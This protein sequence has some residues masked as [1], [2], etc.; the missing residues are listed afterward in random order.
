MRFLTKSKFFSRY[1]KTSSSQGPPFLYAAS[2]A[3]L[4]NALFLLT[5]N[6]LFSTLNASRLESFVMTVNDEQQS[7]NFVACD[8]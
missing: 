1:A 6:R 3:T 2:M 8:R 5:V 7:I 4:A